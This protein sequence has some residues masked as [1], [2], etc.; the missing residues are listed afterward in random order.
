MASLTSVTAVPAPNRFSAPAVVDAARVWLEG[1]EEEHRLFERFLRSTGTRNRCYGLTLDEILNLGGQTARAELF[2]ERA[3]PIAER[4][5]TEALEGAGLKPAEVDS[6]IFTSCTAPLIPSLDASILPAMGFR[7]NVN[8]LPIYQYGCAGGVAG[9]SV[10]KRFA[11]GGATVLL[12]SV[13]LC[14]LLFRLKE[15]T[16]VHLL[17]AALFADGAGAAVVRPEGGGS[18]RSITIVGAQ[19]ALLPETT[20]LMGYNI[21]EDGNHLRLEKELPAVLHNAIGGIIRSFLADQG[22]TER[23]V[24]WWLV[25]PGGMKILDGIQAL[26][27]LEERQIAWSADVLREVGNISS[28]T[29]LFVL[30]DFLQR[31]VARPG[32]YALMVGIGPGLT[33]ELVLFRL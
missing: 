32:E 19:S 22:L 8:R 21:R 11:D 1:R 18:S 17:G 20:S 23:D 13:E 27:Q 3:R 5:I 26:F 2:A 29:V 4:V 24:P 28:A 9:L 12:L 15:S 7:T 33:V 16:P 30:S 6:V 31:Q 25:H 14:S 10:A